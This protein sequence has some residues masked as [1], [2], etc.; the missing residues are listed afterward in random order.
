MEKYLYIGASNVGKSHTMLALSKILS[1]LNKNVAVFDLTKSQGSY[2]YYNYNLEVESDRALS[3]LKPIIR[4]N[5]SIF[6]NNPNLNLEVDVNKIFKYDLKKFDYV[7]IE[8]DEESAT[9]DLLSKV[10]KV[11]LIQNYDK[12]KL[13]KNNNLIKKL[14]VNGEKITFIFNQI[15]ESKFDK[16]YLIDMLMENLNNKVGLLNNGDVEIP[17]CEEDL[18]LSSNNKV[19][20]VLH[21]KD[22]SDEFKIAMFELVSKVMEVDNKKFNKIMNGRRV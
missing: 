21:L 14:K 9:K 17:F 10:D 3:E 15:L 20:G 7:F 12:D 22:Y 8:V 16:V 13:I 11:F 6:V 5:V 2:N 18:I 4:D 19:D 1:L